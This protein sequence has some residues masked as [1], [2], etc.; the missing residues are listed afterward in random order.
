MSTISVI[1]NSPGKN[2][3]DLRPKTVSALLILASVSSLCATAQD[4]NS[5]SMNVNVMTFNVWTADAQTAKLAEIIQAGAADIVGL[6]EMDADSHGI[7]LANAL[8]FHYYNQ[9]IRGNR[10]VSRYPIVGQS[11]DQRG[12]QVE[13]SPGHNTWVYN[14]H[15]TAYPYGPYDLRDNPSLTEA[16]LIETANAT[17]GA[18]IN[19]YLGSI[20]NHTIASDRVFF[21]GDFNEPS[22]LDWTQAAADAT[23]RTFDKKVA[24]PTSEKAVNA[25]FVDSFR[26]VRPNEVSDWG[27]TWTPG[28]PPPFFNLGSN[29]VHDRIDIVYYR[30]DGVS[31]LNSATVGPHN[32]I[33]GVDFVP[34]Y[35]SDIGVAGYNSDH[36]A[37][38]SSFAVSGLSGS[39]L[40][41]SG[42]AHNPGN[43]S[44]L[45][46]GGYGDRLLTTPNIVLQ[47]DASE[48][49][50]W[51]T[52][53]GNRVSA[54]WSNN[55]WEWGVAQLQS[56]GVNSGAVFDLHFQPDDGYAVAV[57][58]FNL[59]DFSGF[60][61]GHT[62][63]WQLWEGVPTNGILMAGSTVVV[64]ENSVLQIATNYARAVYNNVTLRIVHLSGDGSDLAIDDIGFRQVPEPS[65]MVLSIA[66]TLCL[67][68]VRRRT[69]FNR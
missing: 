39:V 57:D 44:A 26:H 62:V 31:V 41:F 8:G 42:L 54:T 34:E 36:R 64:P 20:G 2:L 45:N 50:T 4:N 19:A 22:H 69:K 21:T 68:L 13:L 12:V 3:F 14:A 40:T 38:V 43:D 6:Q 52:Y 9:G 47:F 32:S 59:V 67:V 48:N 5:Y 60:A 35:H 37:V 65:G 29:E 25:G 24:W 17:R 28:E 10:I 66:S 46:E 30:G 49:A 56:P 58:W 55:N 1:G 23:P 15:L 63:D 51:D 7:A 53:D 16:E 18:E 11:W 27:Y 33:Y 61:E